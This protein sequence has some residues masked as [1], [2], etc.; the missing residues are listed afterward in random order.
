[1]AAESLYRQES[2]HEL[3]ADKVYDRSWALA[4]LGRVRDR[5]AQEYVTDGKAERFMQLEQF[6]PGQKCEVTYAEA[7]R[8]LGV[9]EGT[10]KS[11]VSRLKKRYGHIL[12]SE[13][14]QTVSS[15][16]E[17]NDELRYLIAVVS[18]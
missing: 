16:D 18:G 11:D 17:I 15:V 5:L 14:A 8:Q 2:S 10:L 9:P 7:A 3:P 13:I 1:V 6:L 12:R 4:M